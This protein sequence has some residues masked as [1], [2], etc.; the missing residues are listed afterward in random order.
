LHP[1]DHLDCDEFERRYDAMP[2]LKKAELIDGV[3][4]MPSPTRFEEH[5]EPHAHL[6][7]WLALYRFSTPGVRVGDNSTVRLDLANEPQPDAVLLIDPKHGGQ[8]TITDGYITD[9]PELVVEVAASSVS[10]DAHAKLRAYQQHGIREYVLWRV[11]DGAIDWWTLQGGQYVP[12]PAGPDGIIRS[13]VF[14]GLWVDP[15]ALIAEDFARV[16][17]ALQ[18]GFAAPAHAAFVARLR[19]AASP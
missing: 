10:I 4:Y 15:R 19:Q 9:G 7:G 2:D 8:A 5:G 11:E 17:A 14:P 3:V 12:L 16:L 6:M 1:G 13:E 18:Q